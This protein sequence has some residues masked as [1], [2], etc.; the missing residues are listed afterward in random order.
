MGHH[1]EHLKA[2]KMKSQQLTQKIQ[3]DPDQIF[4]FCDALKDGIELLVLFS[5][6]LRLLRLRMQHFIVRPGRASLVG[7]LRSRVRVEFYI[8]AQV[9]FMSAV[10]WCS[11]KS[12]TWPTLKPPKL[13]GKLAAELP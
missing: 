5:I 2:V 3:L 7:Y 13:Q 1:G 10:P 12:H 8:H 11:R 6:S 4:S 9:P